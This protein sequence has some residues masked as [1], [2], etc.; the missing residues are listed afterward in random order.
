MSYNYATYVSSLQSLLVVSDPNGQALLNQMLPNIIDYAEQRIYRELDLIST[1][2]S[3]TSTTVAG[4]RSVAVQT[5]V[6]VLNSANFITPANTLPDAGTRNPMRRVSEE[7][8]NYTWSIG[9]TTSGLTPSIAEYYA[10]RNNGTMLIAPAPDSTYAIEQIGTYRPTPLSAGNPTTFLTTYLPDLF[11]AAS[12]VFAAGYQ[13]DF[14]QQSD[15][16]QLAQSWETQYKTLFASAN[17]EEL[18]KKA[19]SASDEPFTYYPQTEQQ[20]V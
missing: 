6:I 10:L 12:M 4:V 3:T 18:R 13:R 17:V 5:G 9:S 2:T 8:L 16:P 11:L 20:R 7:F 19:Q 14:G 15:D 1:I